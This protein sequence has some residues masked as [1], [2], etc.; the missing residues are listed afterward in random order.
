MNLIGNAWAAKKLHHAI[1][2]NTLAQSHLF[3]GPPSVGKATLAI[4]LAADVLSRGSA[5]P[6]RARRLALQNKHP[7]LNWVEQHAEK[8]KISIE[9]IRELMQ[10]L[11][12]APGESQRRVGVINDAHV[13]SVEG[14]N[15]ILKT[16]EEPSPA[17][18]LILITPNVDALLPTIVSRCQ[19]MALRPVAEREIE[20]ALVARGADTARAGELAR[21]ARG[22]VGWAIRALG[23]PSLLEQRKT[24]R[25]DL[26]TLAAASRTARLAYSEKLAREDLPE[27]EAR[28]DEWMVLA[29]EQVQAGGDGAL[30]DPETLRELMQARKRLRQNANARLVLDALFLKL[31]N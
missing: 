30:A 4:E 2:K 21:F 19:V 15:A 31:T 13:M 6:A 10:T 22:R 14:Q 1:E 8:S 23:D 5:D 7:D 28:L 11:S 27:I 3:V 17:V 29:R 26:Q 24:W 20:Q 25:E 12:R 9:Q 18:V 16:L